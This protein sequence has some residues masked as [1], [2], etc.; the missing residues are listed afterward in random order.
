MIN[1]L[2][3]IRRNLINENKPNIYLIYAIG[4]VVL[5]V[6][7]ILIA[8]Q[9][10]NWNE[11]R[12]TESVELRYLERLKTDLIQDSLYFNQRIVDARKT[13]ENNSEAIKIA[14]Q[15]QRNIKD[16]QDLMNLYNFYSEHLTIQDNSF[17]E[18]TS[19]GKLNILKNEQLKIEIVSY[20]K[21]S[22]AAAK[23]IKEYNEYSVT[24]VTYLNNSNPIF[25][26]QPYSVIRKIF[27]DEKM[28]NDSDWDFIND[29]TSD[30]FRT[31]ENCLLTYV[32]KQKTLLPYYF[33]LRSES[34]LIIELIDEEL[35]SRN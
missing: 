29:P 3:R 24:L 10:D 26:Y 20:Y 7:G 1:F 18:M 13:I 5:V 33:D 34:K 31:L 28:F 12:K 9:I 30:K 11:S 15:S 21:F 14:Y 6:F 23:H 32:N 35:K 4:E 16:L 22:N 8:F 25:K 2:R 19:A 17:V 27:N